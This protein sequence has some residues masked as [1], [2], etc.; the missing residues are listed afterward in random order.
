MEILSFLGEASLSCG[1]ST[2]AMGYA[3]SVLEKVKI[4]WAALPTFLSGHLPFESNRCQGRIFVQHLPGV[5]CLIPVQYNVIPISKFEHALA[6]F[7][8][9]ARL[10]PDSNIM[11]MG[12]TK[13]KKAILSKVTYNSCKHMCSLVSSGGRKRCLLL[14]WVQEFHRFPACR[15]VWRGVQVLRS[16]GAQERL[17]GFC[18]QVTTRCQLLIPGFLQGGAAAGRC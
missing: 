4:H 2:A 11:V 5:C 3:E 10:A 7:L 14:S 16:S 6:L 1:D 13:C 17:P 18:H 9:G 15:W 8:R 12:I